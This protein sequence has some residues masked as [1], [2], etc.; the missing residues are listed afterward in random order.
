[1]KDND[2]MLAGS[3]KPEY[4]GAFA[5]YL[6]KFVEAYEAEGIPIYSITPQ[7]EPAF[8]N[9]EYPTTKWTPEQQRDF[10]RDHLG[11]LFAEKKLDTEIWCW[12]HNFNYV[13]FPRTIL[14]DPEAAK[15]TAGT[16]F[17]FYEGK[18]QAMGEFAEEFPDKP[19]YFTEGSAFGVRGAR[20]IME[21]LGNYA[22]CYNAWVTVL[23]EERGPNNGP[24]HAS[25]TII[26]LYRDDMELTYNFDYY[27]Y[28]HF[29]K[30]IPRG[31][32]RLGSSEF[33]DKVSN[34]AFRNPDGSLTIVVANENVNERVISLVVDGQAVRAELPGRSVNTFVW[35]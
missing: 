9:K 15:Y 20:R 12:D 28:G 10:I 23:D 4:Y 26:T 35:P 6:A 27:M 32:V 16:A 5:R 24:H 19:V 2:S 18:P 17:H 13:K 25:E 30:F 14:S 21:I 3:V 7:N 34:I 8:P 29:M 1:M 31:A 22:R 33:D 11:P